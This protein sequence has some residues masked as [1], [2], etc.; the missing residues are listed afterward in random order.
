MS[1]IEANPK[2]ALKMVKAIII[3]FAFFFAFLWLIQL[4]FDHNQIP[5]K[6]V[7]IGAVV[8]TLSGILLDWFLPKQIPNAEVS[9]F[10]RNELRQAVASAIAVTV[11]ISLA[12]FH[13]HHTPT[14]TADWIAGTVCY[15]VGGFIGSY[16]FFKLI[17]GF[18]RRQQGET[19]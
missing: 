9:R 11:G 19:A 13:S 7:A 16:G 17:K 14:S 3:R 8:L 18:A 1:E 12:H 6:V 10:D 15:L 4:V 2:G 5:L